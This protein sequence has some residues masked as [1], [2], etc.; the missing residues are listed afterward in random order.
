MAQP[1][2]IVAAFSSSFECERRRLTDKAG[3]AAPLTAAATRRRSSVRKRNARTV[4]L[5]AARRKDAQ[6]APS[7]VRFMT[8]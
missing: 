4:V 6:V 7:V 1:R 8:V 2:Q 5:A 3:N